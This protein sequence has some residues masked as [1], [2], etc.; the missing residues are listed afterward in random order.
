M[1]RYAKFETVKTER[2]TVRQ[3]IWRA[4]ALFAYR[5][6][7]I[8]LRAPPDGVPGLRDRDSPCTA[9]DPRPTM[10]G[11][12]GSCESDGHYL[13]AEC[14]HL[15]RCSSCRERTGY[16]ECDQEGTQP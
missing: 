8:P 10:R 11:D 12:W 15:A 7:A 3:R 14:A 2:L 4:V 5:R 9:Y 6:W 13:C 1:R 16:C